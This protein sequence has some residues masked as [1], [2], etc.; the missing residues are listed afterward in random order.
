MS[1]AVLFLIIGA[2]FAAI[3]WWVEGPRLKRLARSRRAM[4][5]EHGRDYGKGM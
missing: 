2:T 4:G 3:A 1:T 5:V